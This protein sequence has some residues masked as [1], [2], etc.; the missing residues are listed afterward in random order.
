MG[1]VFVFDL[2][3]YNDQEFAE[4]YAAG[5][6]DVDRL[7]DS[8]DR[9]LIPDEILTEKNNITVFDGT[10]ENPVMNMLLYISENYEGGERTYIDYDEDE[11]VS[12]FRNLLVAHDDSGFDSWVVLNSLVK[13]I[14]ELKILKTAKGLISLSFRC[15]V[16][17]FKTAQVPQYVKFTCTKSHIKCSL[18]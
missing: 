6:Y 10:N 4:A 11:I 7:K 9:D 3:T 18:E 5:S 13:E 17:I 8:W 15:G 16:K 2:E 14:T 1:K 12:S